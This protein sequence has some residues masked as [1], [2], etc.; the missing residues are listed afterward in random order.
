MPFVRHIPLTLDLDIVLRRLESGPQESLRPDFVT[1]VKELLAFVEDHHLLMPAMA[2]QYLPREDFFSES[3]RLK[4]IKKLKGSL[5]SMVLPAARELAL[6]VI[7]I[8]ATLEEKVSEY[9]KQK[10]LIKAMVLDG[11]GSAALDTLS[12]EVLHII[13]QDVASKG[14]KTSSPLNPGMPGIP[15]SDQKRLFNLVPAEKIGTRLNDSQLMIPQKSISM[16][17]G[18][19]S[20]MP[21]WT[22][23]EVC[24][25]CSLKKTCRHRFPLEK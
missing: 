15:L 8:G 23:A 20:D 24:A 16:I 7:T 9:A 25:R 19:G 10:A 12:L 14:L 1:L 6:V 4:E 3:L 11:V 13:D 2:Y 5:V 18:I 22:L 17:I 21:T